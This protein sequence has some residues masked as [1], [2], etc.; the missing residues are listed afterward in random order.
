VIATT[1]PG[2]SKRFEVATRRD[3]LIG[4]VIVAVPVAVMAVAIF[5]HFANAPIWGDG[6]TVINERLPPTLRTLARPFHEHLN[7]VPIALWAVLPG[8]AAKL[9]A[10]L[11][12]HVVLALA[13]VAFLVHR[14]GLI[15]GVA[16]ALPLALLGTAHFDLIMPW[17]ILFPIPL[18]LGL[19]AIAASIPKERTWLLRGIVVVCVGV[20]AAS[21]NVGLFLGLALGLWFVIERRWWQIAE[22]LPAAIAWLAWFV[23]IGRRATFNGGFRPSLD[24][25]PYMLV[26][27]TSG[28]GGVAGLD[29]RAGAVILV[30]AVA[31]VIWK[32]VRVPSAVLAFFASVCVMFFV[33]SAFRPGGVSGHISQAA[34]GRYIYLTGFMLAFGLALGAPRLRKA[35]WLPAALL[36]A[37]LAATAINVRTLI[38]AATTYPLTC[39][40]VIANGVPASQRA[41]CSSSLLDVQIP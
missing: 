3:V 24:A 26:G 8:T 13:T 30:L 10:L 14:I 11:V 2:V 15:P 5:L 19:G 38:G 37:S 41:G 28:V 23:L 35:R 1:E 39:A 9:A 33:L 21:S 27:V 4:V 6:A 17:Q 32:R 36:V 40:E 12:A 29:F 7:F 20:A 18:I 34:A 31:W 16:T 22:L 25:I